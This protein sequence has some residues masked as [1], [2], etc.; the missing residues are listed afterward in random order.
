MHRRGRGGIVIVA[1]NLHTIIRIFLFSRD[2]ETAFNAKII[3][4]AATLNIKGIE[5]RYAE[6]GKD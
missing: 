3:V 2:R 1:V 5:M 4:K 6:N